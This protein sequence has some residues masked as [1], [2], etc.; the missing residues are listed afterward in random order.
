[1]EGRVELDDGSTLTGG[2]VCSQLVSSDPS[3]VSVDG[4]GYS[5]FIRGIAPGTATLTGTFYGV[6]AKLVVTVDP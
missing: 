6:T 1:M 4:T 2:C 5:G 3:V